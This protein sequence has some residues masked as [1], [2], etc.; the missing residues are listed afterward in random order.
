MTDEFCPALEVASFLTHKEAGVRVLD[1]R[2]GPDWAHS[3]LRGSI[4]IGLSPGFPK[5]VG[6]L[7]DPTDP[8]LLIS[9]PA[10]LPMV[11]QLMQEIG[12]T[13]LKGHLVGGYSSL[14]GHEHELTSTERVDHHALAAEL[15]GDPAPILIDVRQ[16]QEW[17][18]G[19]IGSAPN[20]PL[21]EI[22]DRK[23][24]VPAEGRVILQC[25]GGYRSLIAAS[26]LEFHGREG[27][28]DMAGGY[29]SWAQ[30]G[31]P[32]SPAGN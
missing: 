31:L 17:V 20:V 28:V 6:A 25:L 11:V 18:Q 3:H 12:F 4:F 23:H 16:P 7:L 14:A 10:Q 19:R 1:V 21:T 29:G 8:W 13:D 32:I 22:E 26:L 2:S 15:G 30:A 24:E 27:L 5:W 9:D